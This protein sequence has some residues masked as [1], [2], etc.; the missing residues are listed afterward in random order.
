MRGGPEHAIRDRHAR[1]PAI[2]DDELPAERRPGVGVE[3]D[4]SPIRPTQAAGVIVLEHQ[5]VPQLIGG[6]ERGRSHIDESSFDAHDRRVRAKVVRVRD[7]LVTAEPAGDHGTQQSG[8]WLDGER[9]RHGGGVEE[10]GLVYKEDATRSAAA[11][12]PIAEA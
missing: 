3:Q 4:R 9:D 5:Q 7:H 1:M 11:L 6:H 8:V 12:C 10:E 2:R